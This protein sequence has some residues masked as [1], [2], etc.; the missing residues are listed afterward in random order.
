MKYP[1]TK[2][3]YF[4]KQF[5]SVT[6]I[7]LFKPI[8][9]KKTATLL[10][11]SAFANLF[12]TAQ[13]FSKS[14]TVNFKENKGQV[15]DQ[16]YKPRPDVLFSGTDGKIQF[17]LKNNGISYQ[18]CKVSD[19]AAEKTV[20]HL[21]FY[22]GRNRI[23]PAEK[24]IYRIDVNWLNTT[25]S[26]QIVKGEAL[27]DFE[28]YYGETCPDGALNVKSYESVLY[29]NLYP[30][31]DLKWYEKEAALEYDYYVGAFSDYK[32]IKLEYKGAKNIYINKQGELIIQT[33][34][35]IIAE[36][37][38]VAMQNNKK[39]EANWVV[40]NDI[41][42]F[43]IKNADP[44]QPMI[45]DPMVR[46]WGT[47]Y[48]GPADDLVYDVGTDNAANV[49]LS[50]QTEST[51][52]IA[53]SGAHQ[54]IYGGLGINYGD[55]FVAKF[56]Q[57]G[58]RLWATYYGGAQDDFCNHTK[59]DINGN[60]FMVGG[61]S[62]T[63]SA[64]I[65]TQG[66][67]QSAAPGS[68]ATAFA[69]DAF[70]V[71]F[72]SSGARV[73]GT[74]Y[75]GSSSDWAS[76]VDMNAAGDILMSGVTNSS[77]GNTIATSGCHQPL[78]GGGPGDGF[79]VSFNSSGVRQWGTYYG[80]NSI[81]DNDDAAWCSFDANGDIYLAG[82][83]AS[84][85]GIATS[86]AHQPAFGGNTDGYLAKF[87]SAGVRQWGTYF[88]GPTDDAFLR[89]TLDASGNI[90]LCGV[91]TGPST[92]ITTPGCHQATFGGIEDGILVKFNASGIRQWGS[93][94]GGPG[95]DFALD[96]SL[97]PFGNIYVTGYTT[98]NFGTAIATPC[99][100]QAAYAGGSSDAYLT[101]FTPTGTRIWGSYFGSIFTDVP[102]G[103]IADIHGNVYLA[104]F[105]YANSG[106]VMTSPAA[107]QTSFGG[108]TDCFLQ[109]FDGCMPGTASNTTPSANLLVC[110]GKT[111]TLTASCGNWYS[112]ATGTNILATGGTFTTGA[113]TSDSTF[114]VEDFGCGSITGTRT[115]V[116]VT[117]T[118]SPTLTLIN[119]NPTACVGESILIS[120]SGA[121]TY[122][123][124]TPASSTPTLQ[125]YVF[126]HA[127][128]TVTG[129]DA[130]G[131]ATIATLAVVPNLC[132]GINDSGNINSFLTLYPNPNNGAFTIQSGVHLNLVL[133]NELGQ[134][135]K[136]LT[137]SSTNSFK[138]TISD[139]PNGVYFL[140]GET[141]SRGVN[142]KI[143][144]LK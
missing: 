54:S 106:T 42:S 14:K 103:C 129:T 138:A 22:K 100:Y 50:G 93:Y 31:I 105:T 44:S 73:W 30:G 110:Q 64:V 18:L 80:G 47:Y 123:W 16:F 69:N 32:K 37:N 28:N 143:I 92:A 39:L 75:G 29:K 125:V 53:T 118:P 94:Y 66:T 126:L 20:S 23:V 136:T 86:G 34:F 11:I 120:A 13:H 6:F 8:L 134:T 10:F 59:V 102:G 74:Y 98:T 67:H 137:L 51:A 3:K 58:A 49:Y 132:L 7:I 71:K 128:Y 119:T 133:T 89:A 112:S 52:N 141:E 68:T 90:Y 139:L 1:A 2:Q 56:D 33:P 99:A 96:V 65:A 84:S 85:N 111:T 26:P 35:G 12:L 40:E 48:G 88:G 97:D 38:P 17:H 79:L 107:Y 62:T 60:V 5:L 82:I 61:T 21:P 95:D 127:T 77:D 121:S 113:L 76:Y 114:F 43:D 81:S 91:S 55:A 87:N 140:K 63:N 15:S 36:Q 72:N 116:T 57:T 117:L 108:I 4:Q 135:V 25:T 19:R 109:K 101:K 27:P 46:L 130:I 78:Y 45:I 70:L 41:I 115:A 122:S 144:V 142:Q 9:M 104:G 24:T 131:C 83:T 124:V